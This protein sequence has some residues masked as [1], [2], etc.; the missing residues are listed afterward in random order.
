MHITHSDRWKHSHHYISDDGH[1][2]RNTRRVIFLTLAMMIIEIAAGTLFGSMAL[3]ADGWH[4]GTHAAALGITAFAYVYARRKSDDPNFSFG[5]GKVGVLGGFSSAVI[6]AFIALL[7]SAESFVRLINPSPIRFNEAIFVAVVGLMVNLFSAWLLQTRRNRRHHANSHAH[8]HK[9]H[10]LRAAY[11]HVLADALTSL[12]AIIALST[13]KI[14]GWIWMDPVMGI[15]GALVIARWSYGLLMDTGKILLDRDV[16]REVVDKIRAKMEADKDTWVSDIHVWRVGSH[17]LA[18]IIALVTYC[19]KSPDHYKRL[20]ADYDEIVHLTIEV[21]EGEGESCPKKDNWPQREDDL[22]KHAEE[23]NKVLFAISNAVNTTLNLKDLYRSIHQ[24]L[25]S[26]FDVT[27]F[28][29]A[30]VDRKK[31]TLFFPY[32]VDTEDT[33]FSPLTDFNTHSSLTGLVVAQRKPILLRE[34]ELK[35]RALQDGVWG[36]VPLI[37]LGVPLMVKNTVIGVMALQSYKNAHLFSHQ[38]LKVLSAVSHQIAIAIDRKRSRDELQKSEEQLRAILESSP[39]PI[40]VYDIEGCLQYLNPAFTDVFGWSFREL[41]GKPIPFVPKN[42]KEKTQAKIRELYEAQKP[43]RM[44]TKRLTKTGDMRDILICAGL[45]KDIDARPAGMVVILTDITDKNRL[46]AQFHAAQKLESIGTLAGGIAHDFNNLLM[47]ISGHV[48]LMMAETDTHPKSVYHLKEIENQVKDATNLAKQ[49][50]GFARGGKFELKSTDINRLIQK[51]TQLFGRT[52]KEIRIAEQYE[53]N[54]WPVEIDQGQIEHVI[55]NLYVNA[56]QAMPSGGELRVETKNVTLDG[57]IDADVDID[58]GKYVAITITDTGFGMDDSTRRRI[59]DPFF[60]TKKM[61]RG[62]GLGLASVYGIIR[63]HGGGINVFSEKGKGATF[64]IYLPASDKIPLEEKT[65]AHAIMTGGATIL[66]IDDEEMIIDVGSQLLE[67]LGHTVLTAGSG[68]T[69]L[70]IYQKNQ[71]AIDLV[72]LD[73]IMPGMGGGETYDRLQEINSDIKVILSSGYSV[74][75]QAAEI[76]NRGC[77]GFI[78]KPFNLKGLS[79]KINEVLGK[80]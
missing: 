6:L 14:F 24:S 47:A 57:K 43:V 63:N 52:K 70:E 7:I 61:G 68:E 31:R 48:S 12:L 29:I 40:V 5:T 4:M 64:I 21:N 11:L 15:V 44:E 18:A 76:L 2:E 50:L 23:I 72:I 56:W 16:N 33:D 28:F 77:S 62:T 41:R 38:D 46:T 30:I 19:P 65:P 3:L 17:H 39:D 36:P 34:Q 75:G 1:G 80:G 26:I 32:H 8:T 25:G 58:F 51:Q 10:N 37:W 69:A 55:L 13:G 54:I 60:T 35:D 67:R 71:A 22:L 27:N 73:M 66:L 45:I 74:N 49:L 78:Q 53:N 79:D 42:Q 59:F 9:D 20:L